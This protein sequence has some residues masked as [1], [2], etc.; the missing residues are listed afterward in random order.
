MEELANHR[1]KRRMLLPALVAVDVH[2][3]HEARWT[4][5]ETKI[6]ATAA[7][8]VAILRVSGKI[9]CIIAFPIV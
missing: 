3:I 2:D 1:A 4:L 7:M 8:K 6:E 5:L 9:F